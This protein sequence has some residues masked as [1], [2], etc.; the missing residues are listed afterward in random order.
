SVTATTRSSSSASASA[1]VISRPPKAKQSSLSWAMARLAGEGDGRRVRAQA[2]MIDNG[3]G[4]RR[5][6]VQRDH[7]DGGLGHRTV[8]R[9]RKDVRI[10]GRLQRF[11]DGA[12]EHLELGMRV[13]LVAL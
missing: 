12:A 11:A 10:V 4:D 6:V 8:A 2:Q 13:V 7:G 9:D 5:R 1:V 3:V